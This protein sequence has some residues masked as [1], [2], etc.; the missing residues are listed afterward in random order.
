MVDIFETRSCFEKIILNGSQRT[1]K[2]Y[3]TASTIDS[4]GPTTV[5]TV[6]T[7]MSPTPS[8]LVGYVA[9]APS[10]R[11]CQFLSRDLFLPANDNEET[12]IESSTSRDI[13]LD[14]NQTTK[15]NVEVAEV[16]NEKLIIDPR[17]AWQELVSTSRTGL[18]ETNS[19]RAD[20]IIL[21][22]T[23]SHA[24]LERKE[25][26]DNDSIY[27][28]KKVENEKLDQINDNDDDDDD[29]G[30]IRNK[31][32]VLSCAIDMSDWDLCLAYS[33]QS[34]YRIPA[35]GIHPWYVEY[36]LTNMDD[37]VNDVWLQR[38]EHLL[39]Q[40]PGCIVGE[41][42]L[43]KVAKFLRTYT[44]G[45][46]AALNIQRNVFTK[47]LLLAAKYRRPVSIH[48]VNQH[49]VLLDILNS[50]NDDQIPP[51]LALHSYSGTKHHVRSL[52]NWEKSI[53]QR[54]KATLV[55]QDPLLY[56]GFSHSVNYVMCTS[57]KS[58]RQGCETI[59]SIPRNRLLIESD[60]HCTDHVVLGAVGTIAYVA[61][62]LNES[63]ESVG[64]LSTTNGLRF[65]QQLFHSQQEIART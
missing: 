3:I 6:D 18:S 52:L 37:Y 2:L 11:C 10:C 50:L 32:A 26:D 49:G 40:H 15:L 45:K 48:C 7:Y 46:Q 53:R 36:V 57:V 41:I 17:L 63:I 24:H 64:K 30:T 31:M 58:K 21:V 62:V 51:A 56:F 12:S 27:N 5:H 19:N 61:H 33:K 22:D 28:L 47:Q 25:S 54:Q 39:Q 23:H 4:L 44:Y 9:A 14:V 34:K 55:E 13:S 29:D 35:I 16:D 65:F 1:G 8:N 38:L 20:L 60:V 59:V 42:G 43:C